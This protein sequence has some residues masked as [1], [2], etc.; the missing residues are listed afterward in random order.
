MNEMYFNASHLHA[1]WTIVHY[2][3]TMP[4]RC[5]LKYTF[6][7]ASAINAEYNKLSAEG[8]AAL[9]RIGHSQQ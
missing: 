9:Q 8:S 7:Y 4:Y 5:L 1:I 2:Y 6:N 3:S